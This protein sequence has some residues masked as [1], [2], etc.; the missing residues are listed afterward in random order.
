MARNA[1]MYSSLV[2]RPPGSG[3]W[4]VSIRLGI[5]PVRIRSTSKRHDYSEEK[6][7]TLKPGAKILVRSGSS[8]YW[9]FGDRSSAADGMDEFQTGRGRSPTTLNDSRV[10]STITSRAR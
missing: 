10:L 7:C 8:R 2:E 1:P 5:D 3:K 6:V 4:N 9:N